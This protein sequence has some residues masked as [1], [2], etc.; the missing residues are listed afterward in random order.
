M[1]FEIVSLPGEE[2]E[3]LGETVK[4]NL[5]SIPSRIA[6][7]AIESLPTIAN[8]LSPKYPG[9][10]GAHQAD[11]TPLTR[12]NTVQKGIAQGL[13]V[14][15]EYLS[16]KGLPE[17]V[18]HGIASDL[19]LALLTGNV[20][21][22]SLGRLG[23][24]NLGAEAAESLGAGTV[25]KAISS[26]GL[27]AGFDYLARGGANIKNLRKLATEGYKEDYK[28]L[29]TISKPLTG[30]NP[31][32]RNNIISLRNEVDTFKKQPGLNDLKR[33]IESTADL[34]DYTGNVNL[35][36]LWDEKKALSQVIYNGRIPRS[37]KSYYSRL[38]RSIDD[39]LKNVPESISPEFSALYNKGNDLYA[40]VH[41]R[42]ALTKM[43]EEHTDLKKLIKNKLAGAALLGSAFTGHLG[44]TV[45][46]YPVALGLKRGSQ[47]FDFAR[48]KNARDIISDIGKKALMGD[49]ASVRSSL[50]QLNQE[51]DDYTKES[52]SF[53]IVSLP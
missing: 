48:R 47:L 22:R 3:S 24:S 49:V 20:N 25:G 52:D 51:A 33:N 18:L 1:A 40:A 27:G 16:P 29:D 26:Y 38:E 50:K 31:E 6:T 53:E 23:A 4:R 34:F 28:K 46:A 45:S 15:P 30:K 39:Y 11:L 5:V 42:N 32:L 17:K 43:L 13:G 9:V 14:E 2:Q 10:L 12:N 35:K 8:A 19:P 7:S 44:K 41:G 36:R 21:L 37:L